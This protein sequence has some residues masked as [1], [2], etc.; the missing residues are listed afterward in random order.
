MK[1]WGPDD[2]KERAKRMHAVFA[3][4]FKKNLADWVDTDEL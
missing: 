3:K 4:A 2:V 1:K